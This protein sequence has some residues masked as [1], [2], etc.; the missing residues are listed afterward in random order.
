M[1]RQAHQAFQ[2][3]AALV[4]LEVLDT[5]GAQARGAGQIIIGEPGAAKL[6]ADR[7]LKA[8]SRFV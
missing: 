4:G 7:L 1:I 3:Q 2:A 5:G 8:F 6:S